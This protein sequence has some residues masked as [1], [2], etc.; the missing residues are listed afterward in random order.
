MKRV[1]IHSLK[2]YK[3]KLLV[4]IILLGINTYLLTYPPKIIGQIV[5]MLYD[6]DTNKQSILN[7]TYFLLIVC[8]VFLVVRITWKYL[9]CYINRGFEKDIKIDYLKYL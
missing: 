7:S 5:D 9:E 4:Q 8:V 1:I 6:L 2:N 3:W